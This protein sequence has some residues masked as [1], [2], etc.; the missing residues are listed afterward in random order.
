MSLHQD[1]LVYRCPIPSFARASLPPEGLL[2]LLFSSASLCVSLHIFVRGE[3][4]VAVCRKLA[5][6]QH[7]IANH[8]HSPHPTHAPCSCSEPL[9]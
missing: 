4:A 2:F 3:L 1:C 6:G 7:N 5:P 9:V 8:L